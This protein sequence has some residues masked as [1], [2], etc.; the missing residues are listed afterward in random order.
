MLGDCPH[1]YANQCRLLSLTNIPC[2]FSALEHRNVFP[3][4][5]FQCSKINSDGNHTRQN[6]RKTK[7]IYFTTNQ[8]KFFDLIKIGPSFTTILYQR[9]FR[10]KLCNN[11]HTPLLRATHF[12]QG[13]G[14]K[15]T[16]KPYSRAYQIARTINASYSVTALQ[17]MTKKAKTL[18]TTKVFTQ[19][20]QKM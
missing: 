10:A 1:R 2:Y 6:L 17:N 4:L 3:T 15:I 14:N 18:R 5:S 7:H 13:Q 12:R 11:E 20:M 19:N 8:E 9:I 16:G